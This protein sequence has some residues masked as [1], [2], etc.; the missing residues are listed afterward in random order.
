MLGAIWTPSEHPFHRTPQRSAT[1]TFD[2]F[3]P[4][5]PPYPNSDLQLCLHLLLRT[6]VRGSQ[7]TGL[8]EIL[9]ATPLSSLA[10]CSSSASLFNRKACPL[11]DVFAVLA[12]AVQELLLSI[13]GESK[14]WL[15]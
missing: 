3:T 1:A 7:S 9:E 13:L 12:N 8:L 4:C 2:L 6:L 5:P 15:F 10:S 14:E 11:K